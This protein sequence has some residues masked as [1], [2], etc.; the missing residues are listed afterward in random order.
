MITTDYDHMKNIIMGAIVNITR[1]E[2]T[3]RELEMSQMIEFL[4]V[5]HITSIM[6]VVGAVLISTTMTEDEERIEQMLGAV[7]DLVQAQDANFT[8]Q[9]RSKVATF[10]SEQKTRDPFKEAMQG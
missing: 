7:R 10:V 2:N 5:M 9:L 8:M 6:T 1:N 3:N 4:G